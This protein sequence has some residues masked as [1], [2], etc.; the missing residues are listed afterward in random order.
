MNRRTF[1]GAAASAVVVASVPLTGAVIAQPR[2]NRLSVLTPRQRQVALLMAKGLTNEQIS[3][4][5]WI[6]TPTVRHHVQ[7]V[8]VTLGVPSR[9]AAIELV[10]RETGT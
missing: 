10:R 6:S 1:L 7:W 5:M 4:S 2:R 9:A 3:R 8:V